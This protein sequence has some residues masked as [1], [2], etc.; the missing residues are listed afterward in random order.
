MVT[1]QLTRR[2][3]QVLGLITQGKTNKQ[4]SADLKIAESTVRFHISHILHK[5]EVGDRTQA[6]ILAIKQGLVSL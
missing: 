4:I 3:L 5:L 2:E 6:V 1:P